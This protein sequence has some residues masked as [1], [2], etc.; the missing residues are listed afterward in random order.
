MLE[1]MVTRHLYWRSP[2]YKIIFDVEETLK[3]TNP[4]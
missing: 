3:I 4:K 1:G 2:L